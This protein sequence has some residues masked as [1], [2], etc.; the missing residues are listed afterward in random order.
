MSERFLAGLDE[1]QRQ[2]AS[3]IRGPVVIIAGAGTGKT[4]TITH[5]IAHAIENG[6]TEPSRTLALTYTAKAA[7]E[8]RLRLATLGYSGVQA[9]TF[10]SAAWRQLQFFWNEAIGGK[11]FRILSNKNEF[12]GAALGEIG[13]G[14]GSASLR[15]L[16]TEIE[17]AKGQEIAPEDY[18]RIA[19]EKFRVMPQGFS[20]M[21]I[22][23]LYRTYDFLKQ[24]QGQLD[25]EDILLLLVGILEEQSS[26]IDRVRN[27]YRNF[28]VDEHQDISPL[29]QRVLNLWLGNRKEICVVGDPDQSIF[30]FAGSSNEYLLGFATKYSDAQVFRLDRNYRSSAQIVRVANKVADRELVSVRGK[31]I[32]NVRLHSHTTELAESEKILQQIRELLAGGVN[33][34]EIAVLF[35]RNDQLNVFAESLISSGIPVTIAGQSQGQRPFFYDGKI[36]EAIR[37]IRGAAIA[38]DSVSEKISL[39]DQVRSVL[40]AVGWHSDRAA[41]DDPR[42]KL[43]TFVEEFEAK[44]N[45]ASLRDLITEFDE[46]ER[47]NVE[48][49]ENAV[50]LSSIHSAKGLEWSHVFLP[51]LREGVLPITYSL[52]SEKLL[53]EERRLF[54]VAVTRAKDGLYLSFAG[55]DSSRFL[56]LLPALNSE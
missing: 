54:Y 55:S 22:S 31:G 6:V 29:Q 37:L 33:P 24:D 51:R 36:K 34:R 9:H 12:I 2:A 27:Q 39:S 47:S 17:W 28:T 5:R 16:A 38:S 4:R 45:G 50:V 11:P 10:H 3:A 46:R 23:D 8:L 14:R 35:R 40:S 1:E 41:G 48:P 49:E 7:S 53:E 25:F 52:E 43:L 32:H 13:R 21:E 30:S 56:S 26:I 42:L 15:D 44:V 20:Y 18:V 19:Q